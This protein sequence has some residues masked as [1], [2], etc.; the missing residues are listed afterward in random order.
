MLSDDFTLF[1]NTAEFAVSAL[2]NGASVAGIIEAGFQ[3]PTLAGYGDGPGSSPIFMLASSSVP[4]N[5]EGKTLV[6]AAGP[7]AGTYRIA[8][9]RHDGT[10]VC[11]L[12]LIT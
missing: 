9:A 10:G 12:E 2:L 7:S 11:T 8:N 5:P 4:S 1:F 3:D 6:I